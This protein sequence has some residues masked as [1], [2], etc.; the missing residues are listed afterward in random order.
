MR[1]FPKIFLR[2][3][4]DGRLILKNVREFDENV[5]GPV[6]V[7]CVLIPRKSEGFLK[8]ILRE[9]TRRCVVFP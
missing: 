8:K 1:V 5:V 3:K 9:G 6:E 7:E 4:K 2:E